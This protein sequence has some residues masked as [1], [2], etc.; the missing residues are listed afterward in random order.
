MGDRFYSP[1]VLPSPN[2]ATI[3]LQR[4]VSSSLASPPPP[5][6]DKP[7]IRCFHTAPTNRPQ[8]P[9][10]CACNRYCFPSHKFRNPTTHTARLSRLDAAP[11]GVVHCS[12]ADFVTNLSTWVAAPADLL[13]KAA[14]FGNAP[15]DLLSKAAIFVNSEH[16]FPDLPS[17]RLMHAVSIITTTFEHIAREVGDGRFTGLAGQV[18]G[19]LA[20]ALE[21]YSTALSS[22]NASVSTALITAAGSAIAVASSRS[23]RKN[24]DQPL[25][26]ASAAADVLLA[27]EYVAAFDSVSEDSEERDVLPTEYDPETIA[28]YFRK[29]PFLAWSRASLILKEC[30]FLLANIA[31]DLSLGRVKENE[32]LRAAQFL[33]LI[34]RLGPT[35]IKIGQALS[36]RPDI[37][38][39][40]YLEA[41]QKLQDRVPPFPNEE[42]RNLI[43]EGLRRPVDDIYSEFSE[44]PVA[45]ASLGQVYKAK[46]RISGE[47][48]AVKVQRPRVLEAISL[49]LYILR[50]I[51]RGLQR[52]SN[53]HSDIISLL[54]HWAVHFFQELDYIQEA[55]N[56]KEFGTS[57]K[58]LTNVVVPKVH[59]PYT[60]SK[61]LTTT[62]VEGEK[63]SES[64]EQDVTKLVSTSLNCY[65]I[66]LLETGFLHA[67][68][69]PGNL[70]RTPD[71]KLCVLDFGLML[72]VTED[73]R[74][75]LIDYISHLVNADYDKVA[76][77]LIKL[78]FISPEMADEEKMATFVPQLS[79]VLSQLVQ[80]G[81]IQRI[82][83]QQIID[84]LTGMANDYVIV[85]P[86]Y[87]A[88]LLRAF[89]ILEG[90]G[91]KCN[92][93]YAIVE[94]CY[95]YIC[96]R[97][98]TDDSP[99]ARMALKYFLYGERE[100]LNVQRVEAILLGFQRFRTLMVPTAKTVES[101]LAVSSIDSTS[102]E[103]L[104]SLFAPEGSFVQELVLTELVRVVDALS[105]EA[106]F[107]LWNIFNVKIFPF[108]Y[109]L[110]PLY[111]WPSP[112]KGL[113]FGVNSMTTITDEDQEAL[114]LVR[115]LWNL[116]GSQV[117]QQTV[118][119]MTIAAGS[120]R[121]LIPDLAL[122]V[123]TA[124]LRFLVMLLHRKALRL[125]DDLDGKNSLVHWNRDPAASARHVKPLR[126]SPVKSEKNM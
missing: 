103:V 38:P 18:L 114:K 17:S 74:Y 64:E 99:R 111:S 126:F 26:K 69:H 7:H 28:A 24:S 32:A 6:H 9:T 76:D 59:M 72:R 68:P 43:S 122:G 124:S 48:V 13:S 86:P 123:T 101:K 44:E 85:I 75:A 102:K 20:V 105:R 87:F 63:L 16:P 95:P 2:V 125:A 19:D 121:V 97:L 113:L 60:S 71:G 106:F 42:A 21:G 73:Q 10:S 22:P 84:D 23:R 31:L 12:H 33:E 66:Q 82:D 41:L 61:V 29:R 90:I 80:G 46:L 58:S 98:L 57:M 5:L 37:L 45:A 25:P 108:P 50:T 54:D 100:Q 93:N 120:L 62:W 91:L 109:F 115:R 96:K 39:V 81:G 35:A 49:D 30:S 36:I 118:A 88:L 79:R 110:P 8:H 94:E 11:I 104:S 53:T 116:V 78:G 83:I 4:S 107:E 3:H 47:A 56:A 27:P 117:N 89:S 112:L 40:T 92:P 51:A 65:L 55:K 14:K 52:L 15:A 119:D 77:D 1:K 67:D 34:T 70:L